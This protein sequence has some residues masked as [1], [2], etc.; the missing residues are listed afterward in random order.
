M[1]ME[2]MNMENKLFEAYINQVKRYPLLTPEE[3]V[4]L[5]KAVES[6]DKVAEQR[7]IQSNLRLVVSIA[8]KYTSFNVPLMDI[9]QE[10]NI[11]LMTAAAKY[12][13]NFN[14]RFSTY[15]YLWIAQAMLR[16]VRNKHKLIVVPHRKEALLRRLNYAKEQ[17][18]DRLG[19]NPQIEEIAVFMGVMPDEISDAMSYSFSISS[20]DVQISDDTN[21]TV[22]E[23]IADTQNSPEEEMIKQEELKE[24]QEMLDTLP[25]TEKSVIYYR[26]NFA[27][28]EK[29]KTLRQVGQM[30]GVSSETVRQ[31]EMRALMKLRN[32]MKNKDIAIA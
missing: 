30:L 12:R 23:L 27:C 19:R 31:M 6:G 4:E 25:T 24:V 9:I 26:Y 11:G 8:K 3:E 15:A 5:A 10:G 29:V 1:H 13:A 16:F 21:S 7:L 17:L 20:L 18:V 32:A 14:T 28:D 22:S 2:A